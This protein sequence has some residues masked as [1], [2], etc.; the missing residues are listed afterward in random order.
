MRRIDDCVPDLLLALASHIVSDM[1]KEN[2]NENQLRLLRELSDKVYEALGDDC[3][4]E[5][6]GY[7]QEE[8]F[9]IKSACRQLTRELQD[10]KG[11]LTGSE[12]K[13]LLELIESAVKVL[14]AY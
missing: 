6:S 13:H 3:D 4:S 10:H 9:S 14:R 7:E 11:E 5:D 12:R 8:K 2:N 1:P